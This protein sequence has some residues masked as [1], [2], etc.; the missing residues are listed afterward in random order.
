VAHNGIAAILLLT[1]VTLNHI[2]R[3]GVNNEYT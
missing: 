2:L 3:P 1:L